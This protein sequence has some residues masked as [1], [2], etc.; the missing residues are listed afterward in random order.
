MGAVHPLMED[1]DFDPAGG[2]P[3]EP[4][5]CVECDHVHPDSKSKPPFNWRCMAHP[6]PP[7]GGFVDP[8]YRPDRP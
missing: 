7:L 4:T 3:D 1:D 6:A 5:L 8:S 2:F